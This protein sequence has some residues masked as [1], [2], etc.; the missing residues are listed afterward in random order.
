[1]K[2]LAPLLAACWVFCF[3]VNL[4]GAE[5]LSAGPLVHEFS[6]TL[7]PGQRLEAVSPLF[8]QERSDGEYR[9]SLCPLFSYQRDYI[10]DSKEFDI[11]YPILTYHRF[12]AE[13]RFQIG[14]LFSF[15][16]GQNQ[17]ENIQSRFTL[18]PVYFQQRSPDPERNYT[19]FLPFYGSLRN[20]LF[21]DEIH[22]V[23]LP[24]YL[25]TK[26]RDVVT[27]NYLVPLFHVRKG[28]ELKGWQFW[29]LVGREEKG[30]TYKTNSLDELETIPGHKKLFVLWPFFFRNELGLG[31]ENPKKVDMLLPFY[32][33]ERSPLRDSSSYV[34]PLLTFTDDREK[35]YRE[36]DF[37]GPFVVFARGEGKT[38][39][40]IWPLF[41]DVHNQNL[42][43]RFYLWPLYKYNAINSPPLK[44]ERTRIA[45]FL[46]SDLTEKNLDT[47]AALRRTDL[48]PLF[49]ARRDYSGNERLQ[50]L[51]VLEPFFPNNQSMERLYSP[52]WSI[53]RSEKNAKTGAASVSFLWNLYRSDTSPAAKKCSLLFGL[54]QYQSGPEGR[55]VRL[56][57]IPV[58]KKPPARLPS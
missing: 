54:F 10:A 9:L 25:Q 40:R 51:S 48:W 27:D 11:A 13:Y 53:W 20:R 28:T 45:F 41:S 47:G 38:A 35:K 49:T 32:A 23:M 50:I 18:F 44:R 8:S 22:F 31:T 12:G 36:F 24:F 43:S 29:P 16:G 3:G 42:I 39:D 58:S 56:F 19:A 30:I 33:L 5:P 6:L 37:I 17:E 1:V 55:Y 52:L 4:G 46:Y 57:Y 21:R 15:A 14:Q 7:E 26:K 34:G 2:D